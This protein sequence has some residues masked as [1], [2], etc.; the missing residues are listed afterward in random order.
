[1]STI[2]AHYSERYIS[3]RYNKALHIVQNLPAS[4]SFQPSREQKLEV[5]HGNIDTQ[6]PGIFD[7]VGRAKWDAWK[8]LEGLTPIEAKHRYVEILLSVCAEA[9]RKPAAKAQVEEIIRSFAMMRPN[10][11]DTDDNDDET[12]D[13]TDDEDE[14]DI[15]NDD[16]SIDEEEQAYLRDIQ[17]TAPTMIPS[18]SMSTI[19]SN[20]SESYHSIRSPTLRASSLNNNNNNNNNYNNKQKNRRSWHEKQGRLPMRAPS[21]DSTQSM[22]TAPSIPIR[23]L[24]KSSITTNNNLGAAGMRPPSTISNRSDIYSNN[25]NNNN[26]NINNSH[27]IH[28]HHDSNNNNNN[29]NQRKGNLLQMT[30]QHEATEP[31]FDEHVDNSINPWATSQERRSV[32]RQYR[33]HPNNANQP[34]HKNNDVDN[35][36]QLSDDSIDDERKQNYLFTS[37]YTAPPLPSPSNNHP[38]YRRRPSSSSTLS[39]YQQQRPYRL[40]QQDNPLLRSPLLGSTTS[41]VTAT[42][43]STS[44]NTI[45]AGHLINSRPNSRQQQQ[46]SSSSDNNNNSNNNINNNNNRLLT[47]QQYT[48]IV[49]LGPSTKRALETLQAEILALNERIDGLRQELIDRDQKELR[50][51][52]TMNGSSSSGKSMTGKKSDNNNDDE[53]W[54]GWKWVL[55]AALKHAVIN[56]FTVFL[57]FFILYKRGS[58]I[59]YAVL[60]SLSKNWYKLKLSIRLNKSIK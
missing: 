34:H 46:I 50:L 41:S 45:T 29:N 2:P 49:S 20:P 4:S 56:L 11:I 57:I 47:E 27:N 43:I 21:V 40:Q 24:S 52:K 31:I 33:I 26:N 9:Y 14:D 10:E 37:A 53:I 13:E 35:N 22:M 54:D 55:K 5:S 3:Q 59:A 19:S 25:N 42:G 58:P 1:M 51:K 8:K 38:S 23:R 44:N 17:K 28:H 12:D 36:N 7:V 18:K 16:E 48:S 6:R 15:E 60:N 32:S 30:Q 39:N